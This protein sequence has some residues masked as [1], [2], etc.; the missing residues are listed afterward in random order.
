MKQRSFN[1]T[2]IVEKTGDS[3]PR[4]SSGFPSGPVPKPFSYGT[5]LEVAYQAKGKLDM[6][7]G[8]LHVQMMKVS[9]LCH[10]LTFAAILA[11]APGA[12]SQTAARV[13]GATTA[14]P[15]LHMLVP[16]FTV[17]TLPV[18]LTNLVNLQY[19]HDGVLVALGYNGNIWLVR[20]SN[21]D[22]LED[23]ASLFWEGKG[24]ITAPIGMDLAP[25]GTPHGN[26]VFFACKGKVMMV[27][28]RDGDGRAEEER[29]LAEGWPQARAGVDTA[30]VCY[31]PKDGAIYFGLGVRWYDNAYEI[32]PDGKAAN[33][34]TSERGAILRISPDFKSREK[35][36]TGVRWPIGLRFNGAGDLFCTDQEG[37]TWLPNGNPFDELLLI[38]KGKHYGFPP[39]HPKHLPNVI[40]EPSV[41]DYGPQHQSTCGLR[42]NDPVDGGKAFGPAWWGG[43]ALV[44]GESRGKIYRT[45]LVKSAAGYVAHNE[46][47]AALN[48]LTIDVTLSPR[49]TLLVATH[50]GAPDWG[51][52]PEGKGLIFE[53]AAVAEPVPQPVLT[54]SE[55]PGVFRV[56]WDRAPAPEAARAMPAGAG[57]T[58]GLYVRA[59]D[60]HETMWPG[61]EVVKRQHMEAVTP[62]PVLGSSWSADGRT[63]ELR[64]PPQMAPEHFN[65]TLAGPLAAD[66][67]AELTGVET[68]W[69]GDDGAAWQGWT[70]HLDSQV[71]RELTNHSSPHTELHRHL[72][73]PGE[74]TLRT[75]LD[76][77]KMLRPAVQPG[78]S[79]DHEPAPEEVTIALTSPDTP[80]T[81]KRGF[82]NDA[83][84]IASSPGQVTH[85]VFLTVNPKERE[86]L[87]LVV[88]CRTTSGT[89]P[90]LRLSWH[91]RQDSHPRAMPLSRFFLPWAR[92]EASSSALAL[93]P[94][95]EIQGGD[96][97]RGREIFLSERAL[98]SK[99]HA[100]RG[101][102]GKMGPDLSN[103]VSR[104]YASTLRDIHDPSAVMNPDYLTHQVVLKDGREI[105]AVPRAEGDDSVVLGIG[106]GAELRVAKANIV[107]SRAIKS[108]LMPAKLNEALGPQDFR[109]LMAFL[110]TDPPLMGVYAPGTRPPP[111]TPAEVRDVLAGAP[112][113]S[114]ALRPLKVLL[115]SGPKDHGPGEHDYPRWRE[116]WG[117][118]F[119]L[120]EKTELSLAFDWPTPAQWASADAVMFFRKGDWSAERAK[121][122]DAF[123]TRGGGAVF[124]HW[125]VEGGAQAPALAARI[126]FASNSALTKYRHGPIGL[127]F[128]PALQ[129]PIARNLQQVSFI[130]ETYWNLIPSA[131]SAPKALAAAVEDGASHP[132]CW[133]TEPATGGRI[134]VTLGGHYSW[135]FDDPVFRTLVLRGLAW[136]AKEPVDRFNNLV[137]AGLE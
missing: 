95:P 63:L 27:T 69:K 116:T 28:D 13:Q 105:T 11:L 99:C 125:A 81:V 64:V 60:R 136:S 93:A 108:S 88:N 31:D 85:D 66:L 113:R 56:S 18:D 78:A 32:G 23:Q 57:I 6:T 114:I 53:I 14:P 40:D 117:R 101:T 86:W 42:F 29:V 100:V 124:I 77:W 8:V 104:D 21:G 34:L 132:Q 16:G 37:A 115:I 12:V 65:L 118:L 83:K 110:L 10:G 1:G 30:S 131:D 46:I 44:A 90:N 68:A 51:T 120:A 43:D 22:G 36:C 73:R 84:A 122:L 19:R 130:D 59:G 17:R 52:G 89:A 123:L 47:I 62:V 71:S 3:E 7:G 135:T 55:A 61:Y 137:S 91:T 103:L 76:L 126:G 48:Q 102:G 75:R 82:G 134:F 106:A 41:F 67:H 35:L 25:L 5:P 119:T 74:L 54:W 97:A 112:E 4:G 33:D 45:K 98:C 58:R 26:A 92:P 129:H 128:D 2:G 9:F 24:K 96:W 107:S 87:D 133:I 39:H 20:D 79:L 50:S 109:D 121:D 127:V 70:P 15:A 38:E 49:G 80:F 72:A 111:R 94:R